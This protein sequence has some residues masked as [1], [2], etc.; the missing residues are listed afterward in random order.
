MR[1]FVQSGHPDPQVTAAHESAARPTLS[2]FND[3][4]YNAY[5]GVVAFTTTYNSYV[6]WSRIGCF[7]NYKKIALFKKTQLAIFVESTALACYPD[8][9]IRSRGQCY[10]H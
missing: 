5:Y 2:Q 4:S 7:S 1:K 3:Y 10:D 8:R 9:G 6:G